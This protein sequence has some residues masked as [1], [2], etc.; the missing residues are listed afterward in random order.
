METVNQNF[1]KNIAADKKCIL[2]KVGLKF[3][4]PKINIL[5]KKSILYI[6]C[7]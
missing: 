5:C 6:F 7:Y 3:Q 2:R 1:R 4:N